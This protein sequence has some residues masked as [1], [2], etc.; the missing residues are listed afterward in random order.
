M[1]TDIDPPRCLRG[2]SPGRMSSRR[3]RNERNPIFKGNNGL[4]ISDG[5]RSGSEA[6]S[7]PA[8]PAKWQSLETLGFPRRPSLVFL[9]CPLMC[10]IGTFR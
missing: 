1:L 5:L 9:L 6:F 4:W 2:Y 7:V 3:G 8:N 10:K